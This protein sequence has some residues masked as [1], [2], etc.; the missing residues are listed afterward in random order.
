MNRS[1][2][3][4][5]FVALLSITACGAGNHAALV[6][7]SAAG[8]TT[9]VPTS[10]PGSTPAVS[11]SASTPPT[12]SPSPLPAGD[13]GFLRHAGAIPATAESQVRAISCSGQIGASDP[14]AIVQLHTGGMVLRDY[15]NIAAPRTVCGLG[16]AAYGMTLIDAH[17]ILVVGEA[18]LYAVVD[19]PAIHARWFELPN[20]NNVFSTLVA[21]S[22]RLDEITYLSFAT[23]KDVDDVHV[24]S[25]TGD[26]IVA[27]LPNPHAGRCGSPE[28]SLPGGYSTDGGAAYVLDQ[29][30]PTLNS[31]LVLSS[32]AKA[33]LIA[34]QSVQAQW[35]L[36]Q[37]PAMALWSPATQTLYYRKAGSVYTWT[38]QDG[39]KTFLRGISWYYPTISADGRY[40]AYATLRPDGAT[41]NVY[42]IDLAAGATPKLIGQQRTIPVFLN[43]RQLWYKTEGQGV[44]GPGA[45]APRVYDVGQG[46]EAA[47]I[48]DAV[49]SVWPTTSS[50][51]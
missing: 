13:L 31:L 19:V 33:L 44:C 20:A 22:P 48:I 46:A 50:N 7:P 3:A 32:G 41:H 15:A 49:Y 43:S 36:G 12:A 4:A 28:D 38:S 40:L 39:E 17:H 30:T 51:W 2:S 26:R 5:C 23:D 11:P 45:S 14:V 34:P 24:A 8:H 35:T 1:A 47:S 9:A 27:S 10:T 21:V 18:T 29:P 16:S 37:Q 25:R 6:T 42:L